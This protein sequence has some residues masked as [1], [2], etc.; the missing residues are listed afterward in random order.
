MPLEP[1]SEH[2]SHAAFLGALEALGGTAWNGRLR[3]LLE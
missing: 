1:P 3:Q 2:E